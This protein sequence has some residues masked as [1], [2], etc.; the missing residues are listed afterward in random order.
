MTADPSAVRRGRGDYVVCDEED[1]PPG[2]V[3]IVPV[4]KFGVGVYNVGGSF[5]A[6]TNY[7]PHEGGPLCLGRIQGT[8]EASPIL[9]DRVAYVRDGTV[10]RCPWH[11]WEFDIT[12]GKS[13]GDPE[14][15]IRIYDVRVEEGKV[16]LS[17]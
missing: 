5:F 8:N 3:T 15:G 16:I 2:S 4:G 12:T 7:C 9:P 17:R 1:L 11:S 13:L 6:L 10:I 14:R